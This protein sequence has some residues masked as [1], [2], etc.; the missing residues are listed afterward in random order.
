MYQSLSIYSQVY[1]GKLSLRVNY[2]K[3]GNIYYEETENRTT[4]SLLD[5][6]SYTEPSKSPHLGWKIAETR[7]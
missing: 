6:D 4:K 3:I 1:L 7:H 2:S 5:I